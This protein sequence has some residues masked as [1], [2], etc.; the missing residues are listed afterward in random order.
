MNSPLVHDEAVIG[1]H[2]Q[3]DGYESHF[4]RWGAERGEDVIVILHG[5]VSHSGWQAPF[6]EAVTSASYISF[7]ALDRRGSG[8]NRAARGHLPSA[9]REIED[10]TSF[11]TLLTGLFRKVHL[12]GWCFGG[13]IAAIAAA[14]LAGQNVISSLIMV[15]PGFAFNERYGDVLRLSM[16]AVAEVTEELVRLGAKTTPDLDFVPVPLQATDF[17]ADAQ[18][19]EFVDADD[20]RLR[21]VSQ[22]TVAVWEQLAVRSRG[23]VLAELGNL[24]VLAIFGSRDRLVDNEKVASMLVAKVAGPAPTIYFL[25]APH[26]VHFEE[27]EE[28]AGRVIDFVATVR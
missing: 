22:T 27:A 14:E 19:Q 18:W 6:A 9:D 20:L 12:A 16:Q 24:P 4:R 17:T 1:T 23:T 2:R 5:G 11:V 7:L 8:L 15:S 26:A 21:K 13:Q 3:S 28:L 10:V 25:D